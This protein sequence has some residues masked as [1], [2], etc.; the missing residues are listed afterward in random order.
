MK[1]L[2]KI[3]AAVMVIALVVY[4]CPIYRTE[5]K[6][7]SKSTRKDNYIVKTKNQHVLN[8][9]KEKYELSG[10][11]NEEATDFAEQNNIIA[12]ETSSGNA[13]ELKNDPDIELVEKDILVHASA[14]E[15][16][17]DV[18]K[19][20]PKRKIYQ[21]NKSKYEW[22]V[23][24]VSGDKVK[25]SKVKKK[26]RV[27]IAILDS[28]IDWGNDIDLIGSYSLVPGE[29][30]MT[31]LFM[32][33]SGHGSSVAGIIAA[34]DN[35]SGITGINPNAD[36]L[37]IRVLDN[38]DQAPVSRVVEGIYLAINEKVDIINMSFG[39]LQYSEAL[40]EAIDQAEDAG[41]IVV[42]A[43]GNTG[44][45]GV[46][47]PAA[48]ENVIAVGAVDK[49]GQ[50]TD[51]S[52]RGEVEI[53]APGEKVKTTGLLGTELVA[54]GTSLSAPH[55]TAAVSL[56]LQKDKS[57]TPEFIREL[58]RRTANAYGAEEQ[59]GSGLLDIENAMRQYKSFKKQYKEKENQ[60]ISLEEN[61]KEVVCFK[62]T[63]CVEGS[64]SQDD[65][66]SLIPADNVNVRAGIRFPDYK[67]GFVESDGTY[68]YATIGDNP[69]WHGSY[70]TNYIMA[71]EYATKLAD[72]AGNA[73][74]NGGSCLDNASTKGY[75]HAAKMKADVKKIPWGNNK[76]LGSKEATK[77]RK[78]AFIWGM[79][80]HTATDVYA[81]SVFVGKHHL[82]HETKEENGKEVPKDQ[83]AVAD[84]KTVYS[85]RYYQD[86]QNVAIKCM[87]KYNAKVAGDYSV[88]YVNGSAGPSN[89]KIR[90]I[91]TFVTQAENYNA[92]NMFVNYNYSY[93]PSSK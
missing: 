48:L 52:A 54:S 42:A 25:K 87:Q 73:A 34:K 64:W 38:D 84:D 19:E 66:E 44:E 41:I 47:Y 77:G 89:Y 32:D 67:S 26:D 85:N 7:A 46:E 14:V 39:T 20:E 83:W 60:K 79:A 65:H 92:G 69:W 4:L 28:G 63:G 43:A 8:E 40:K 93:T 74:W 59:Y 37:S 3:G 58:L 68:T 88:F 13:E 15:N 11:F 17:N 86:A 82:D 2:R 21:N 61:T 33:G 16:D 31:P 9:L 75:Q 72:A 78:R 23:R 18:R 27:K 51:E 12:I 56:L 71:F 91:V 6:G 57:V 90:D 1:G 35:G 45:Q 70:N 24:T 30:E 50:V 49:M 22:N 62:D 55:V 81:H 76:V 53:V 10:V 5:I 29:E 80:I 36:I